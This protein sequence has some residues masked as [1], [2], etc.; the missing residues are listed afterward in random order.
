MASGV[1]A[2]VTLATVVLAPE[3]LTR[4]AIARR[5]EARFGGANGILRTK[6]NHAYDVVPGLEADG[7]IRVVGEAKTLTGREPTKLFAA[8]AAGVADWRGF[9]AEP[10]TM[11]DAMRRALSRLYS[12]R[13][14]DF[15]MMLAIID[16]FEALLQQI[17][18]QAVDPGT[19]EELVDHMSV[20][21]SRRLLVAQLQWCQHARDAVNEAMAGD[22][23]R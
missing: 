15:A 22:P 13:H 2:R 8:T 10:I 6:L 3:P 20:M 5:V 1:V 19:P 14:G 18:H 11:P 9:L 23:R 21:W 12:V 16:R 4:Y 7:L 17:V